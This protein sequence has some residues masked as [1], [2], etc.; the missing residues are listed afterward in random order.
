MVVMDAAASA[1]DPAAASQSPRLAARHVAAV[2]VGN[3]LE[4]YDFLTYAFFAAQIGRSFFPSSDPSASLLASLATFGAGFLMRPVGALVIG[5]LGDRAGRKPAMLITFMLMGVAMV[6]LALTP[7]YR[8]IG[9]AAPALAILFRLLQGFALGGEI[10]PNTAWLVE[11]APPPR[12]GPHLS[13]QKNI[14]D[15][16][17]IL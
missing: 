11:A 2:T 15:P 14:N 5:R 3:A 8:T 9:V 6:G 13:Y 1:G 17:Q 4:F 7:S 16:T 12:P 10:G